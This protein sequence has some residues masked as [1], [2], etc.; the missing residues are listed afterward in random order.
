MGEI[1]ASILGA[2]IFPKRIDQFFHDDMMGVALS[3]RHKKEQS[4][5]YLY[6]KKEKKN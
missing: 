3:H 4:G 2:S 6:P 1:L 5:H